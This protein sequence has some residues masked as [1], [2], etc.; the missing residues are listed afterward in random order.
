MAGS[1]STPMMQQY[2]AIKAEHEDCLLFYRMGDFYELF[3][4]DAVK[5]SQCLGITLTQRG[6]HDGDGIPMAGVPYHSAEPYLSKLIA[7]GFRVAICEQ[8]EDPAEAKKRGAK[9][10]VAREVKRIVTPGTITESD[11]LPDRANAYLAALVILRDGFA[12]AWA[13]VSTGD[14]FVDGGPAS[15]GRILSVLARIDPA[16]LLVSD[17]LLQDDRHLAWRDAYVSVLSPLP[18]SRF[19]SKNAAERL[20]QFFGVGTLEALGQF[21]RAEIAAAGTLLD[22]LDLT[23]KGV[24]PRLKTLKAVES[25]QSMAIDPATRKNLEI[26]AKLDGGRAGSLIATVDRTVTSMGGRL[27]AQRLSAPLTDAHAIERRLDA[28]QYF[29]D[30]NLV[31]DDVQGALRTCPDF[32]RSLSRLSVG[33]GGPRDLAA[34]R[35]A[36]RA[37]NAVGD[38]L[39]QRLSIK[40]C[41]HDLE[42][43]RSALVSPGTLQAV[44]SD[45]LV[46]RPPMLARDGGLVP[47]GVNDE[48]DR[49]RTLRQDA[50][51]SIAALQAQYAGDVDVP[52][53]KIK[54]NNVLGYFIEVTAQH[55]DKLLQQPDTYIHRQTMANAMRFTTTQLAGLERDIGSAADRALSIEQGIFDDLV[56]Q[57]NAEADGLMAMAQALASIDVAVATANLAFDENY[58]RPGFVVAPAT[59]AV[60]AIEGGRHPVVAQAIAKDGSG[61]FVA[62]DVSLSGNDSLW[63]LTGPNMSGKSTFLR[64]NALIVLMAQAGLF[65]PAAR[66]ELSCVDRLFSRVGAADDLARGRSTF[67]VEMVETAAILNQATAHSFVILDEIGRGTATFDGLSIAWACVEHLVKQLRCRGLFATHYHELNQLADQL[68]ALTTHRVDVREWQGDIVFLHRVVAGAADKSYGVQ[69]A[70]LAGLPKPVVNR[71]QTVLKQLEANG[72]G[73]DLPLFAQQTMPD[74]AIAHE[75]I[76]SDVSPAIEMLADLD[77]DALTPREALAKLYDLKDLLDEQD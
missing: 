3:F 75:P 70:K 61:T 14:F 25:G 48:L 35:D 64:Q 15:P 62:N 58:C 22:Y 39:D 66:V 4:D 71:A 57:V 40:L 8:T 18:G 43:D 31:M 16:E 63:L 65:V 37:A 11:L 10:V 20:L 41:P 29:Y 6:T 59:G 77:V 32:E 56:D 72:A 9:S 46:D 44:L 69:V 28:A 5:A 38:M 68:P 55:A 2:L 26:F 27:L 47:E 36:L 51:G 19:D 42:S 1:K 30:D 12:V 49:L 53:L 7:S 23:Q 17:K 33:R 24:L 54:H 74:D 73:A 76:A 21:E 50:K 67:M 52:S 60:L 45:F 34:V 13:D